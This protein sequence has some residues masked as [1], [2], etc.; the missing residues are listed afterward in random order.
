MAAAAAYLMRAPQICLSYIWT[1]Y[2]QHTWGAYWYCRE[3][4]GPRTI[5]GGQYKQNILNI[6]PPKPM[7]SI[8]P[9]KF[10]TFLGNCFLLRG[11]ACT[12][13]VWH[14]RGLITTLAVKI[15]KIL[16]AKTSQSFGYYCLWS[17]VISGCIDNRQHCR[18][19]LWKYDSWN[20]RNTHQHQRVSVSEQ[21]IQITILI[22]K[23]G[24]CLWLFAIILQKWTPLR[25][26]AKPSLEWYA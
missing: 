6:G 7:N 8:L 16:A 21:K 19:T 17:L 18:L 5:V 24:P 11:F 15:T 23:R 22:L 13:C 4:N 9:D 2:H 25:L 12:S 20:R 1:M 14:E 3:E 26:V 10:T